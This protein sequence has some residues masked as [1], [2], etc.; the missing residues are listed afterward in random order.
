MFVPAMKLT[1]SQKIPTNW[2]ELAERGARRVR[3]TFKEENV[4]VVLAADEMRVI[5]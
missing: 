5:A 4:D 3:T 1:I 2:R